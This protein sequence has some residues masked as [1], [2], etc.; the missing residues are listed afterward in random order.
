MLALFER[1]IHTKKKLEKGRLKKS[2][3]LIIIQRV[4]YVKSCVL[5]YARL[6]TACTYIILIRKL[7]KFF[8][9]YVKR[10]MI[11]Y[12][13]MHCEGTFIGRFTLNAWL[14]FFFFFARE[15]TI[16]AILVHFNVWRLLQINFSHDGVW[17]DMLSTKLLH[18]Y[19]F[20]YFYFLIFL[21]SSLWIIDRGGISQSKICTFEEKEKNMTIHHVISCYSLR[22]I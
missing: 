10:I 2:I 11:V 1:I 9:V 17:Q 14:R 20:F 19:L 4:I 22:F 8:Y 7:C 12:K 16:R 3:P 5:Q 18:I 15:Y 6:H 13:G 21:I